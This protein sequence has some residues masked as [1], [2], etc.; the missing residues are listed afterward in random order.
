[1][2][3]RITKH[4]ETVLRSKA[5]SLDLE[6]FKKDHPELLKDMWETMYAAHGVGLAAPQVALSLRL[7]VI[8]VQPDAP[9][10]KSKKIVLIN[11]EI[12]H[13]EGV[14][15]E[16]EGCLSIPGLYAKVKRAA[17]VRV[18]AFN[19]H[20]IPIEIVGQG[21]L[22]RALQHEIDHLNGKLFIDHLPF[23]Q[24]LK[25]HRLIR[26]LRKNWK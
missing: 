6:L 2:I 22:G 23:L 24:R 20:G 10:G 21:L 1:M 17:R 18:R 5:R 12:V 4:G 19:E 3:L 13:K 8:D 9:P 11:P 7:A 14:V 25:V 26:Q 16:E 15:S